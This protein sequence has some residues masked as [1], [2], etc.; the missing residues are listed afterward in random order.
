MDV[1]RFQL[2]NLLLWILIIYIKYIIIFLF[3]Y[4][5]DICYIFNKIIYINYQNKKVFYLFF[6]FYCSY[7]YH[8]NNNWFDENIIKTQITYKYKRCWSIII[9]WKSS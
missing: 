1:K 8:I 6:D 7:V 4:K 9:D 2:T 3:V 5:D